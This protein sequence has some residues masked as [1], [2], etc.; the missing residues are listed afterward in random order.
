VL[1]YVELVEPPAL[2]L[3]VDL[4][5]LLGIDLMAHGLT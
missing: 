4:A 3:G 2:A 5:L 1:E